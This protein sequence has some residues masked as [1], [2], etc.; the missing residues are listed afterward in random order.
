MVPGLEPAPPTDAAPA[1]KLEH[2]SQA[3]SCGLLSSLLRSL[4][5]ACSSL[6]EAPAS[7]HVDLDDNQAL[8]I[9]QSLSYKRIA[10][11]RDG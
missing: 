3:S 5:Q 6:R 10:G 11:L 4:L 2:A 8:A 1:A 7:C 9:T